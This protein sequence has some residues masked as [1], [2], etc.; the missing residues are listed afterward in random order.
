VR[1]ALLGRED[2]VRALDM[3][4]CIEACERAFIAYSS[5]AASVPDVIHLDVASGEVHVKAGHISGSPYYA[6]KIAS[7]FYGSTE[8]AFDGMVLVF[9]SEDGRPLAFLMDRGYIT[10]LRTGAAGGVAAKHLARSDADVAAVLGTGVQSR[11]QA[12]ALAL[13]RPSLRSFKVWGRDPGKVSLAAGDI[14]SQTGVP[15]EPSPTSKEAVEGA[16]VV[17]TCTASREPLVRAEMLSPGVHVTAVGSD[18]PGKKELDRSVLERA[19]ILAVDSVDQSERLGELQ[20]AP[21]MVDRA[22]ELGSIC[23]GTT[24]GRTR[25]D[26]ITVCD[27]TG[28]GVQ[29]VA[30]AAAALEGAGDRVGTIELDEPARG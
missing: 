24:A 25:D 4:S 19:D 7:G 6:V 28:L 2:V 3:P 5:G 20:G 14:A 10:D 15:A 18:G 26:Q 17:I 1:V 21:A 11:Y 8:P 27:L 22:V 29:D 16:G 12:R 13:V 9:S 23:A 30:A